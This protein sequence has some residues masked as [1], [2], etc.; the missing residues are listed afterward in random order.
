MK[1]LLMCVLLAGCSINGGS[2]SKGGDDET[3]VSFRFCVLAHPHKV[4]EEKYRC[5]TTARFDAMSACKE[6]KD[7]QEKQDPVPYTDGRVR[8]KCEE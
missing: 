6:W 1:Y 2:F 5:A 3:T 8:S 7:S 4:G